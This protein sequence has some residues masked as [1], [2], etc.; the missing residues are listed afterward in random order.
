DEVLGRA[1]H[2][3]TPARDVSYFPKMSKWMPSPRLSTT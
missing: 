1:L 2:G 3:R